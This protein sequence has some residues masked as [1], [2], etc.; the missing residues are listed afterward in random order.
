MSFAGSLAL[1]SLT[2]LRK[3]GHSRSQLV[4]SFILHDVQYLTPC[5]LQLL[6]Q[7]SLAPQVPHTFTSFGVTH[8]D[9]M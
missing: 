3:V 5:C 1:S 6:V 7:W 9:A 4:W 2:F 8:S